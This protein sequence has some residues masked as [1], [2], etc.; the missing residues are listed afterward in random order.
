[1]TYYG[2]AMNLITY[3]T[4][5]L[6]QD[7]ETAAK[8]TN[9]WTGVTTIIPLIGGFLADAYIGGFTMIMVSSS[10]YFVVYIYT[11]SYIMNKE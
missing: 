5:V 3:L 1:M 2:I 10:F 6:H 8:M 4:G 9:Y 7:L 11:T